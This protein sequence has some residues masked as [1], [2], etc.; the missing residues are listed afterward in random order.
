MI[1][2]LMSLKMDKAR[3]TSLTVIILFSLL[4]SK[5]A[6]A[7]NAAIY[8]KVPTAKELPYCLQSLSDDSLL[9]LGDIYLHER[10]DNESALKCFNVVA[11][12]NTAKTSEEA[13]EKAFQAYYGMWNT[14][15]LNSY[16]PHAAL[17]NLLTAEAIAGKNPKAAGKLHYA[18][19]IIYFVLTAQSTE[20]ELLQ[21]SK[22][23]L[24]KAFDL[25]YAQKDIPTLHRAF[26]NLMLTC[27]IQR[28]IGDADREVSILRNWKN[29]PEP[30]RLRLSLLLYDARKAESSGQ[31]EKAKDYY[32]TILKILPKTPENTRYLATAYS[33][34]SKLLTSQNRNKEAL[35][36]LDSAMVQAYRYQMHDVRLAILEDYQGIYE[37]MG[38]KTKASKIYDQKLM[39][40][41]SILSYRMIGAM[42]QIQGL[43]KRREL[44]QQLSVAKLQHTVTIYALI[45]MAL[46]VFAAIWVSSVIYRKNRKL[47]LRGRILYDRVQELSRQQEEEARQLTEEKHNPANLNMPEKEYERLCV[48]TKEILS[49]IPLVCSPDF[50]LSKLAEALG[51]QSRIASR[52]LN[53]ITGENFCTAVNR[54]RILEACRRLKTTK[55]GK[56]SSEGIALSVGFQS[57]S[58]FNSNFKKITG[59]TVKEYKALGKETS[60]QP[61]APA[62]DDYSDCDNCEM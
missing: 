24:A 47:T 42:S 49:D 14:Y 13:K 59:L 23:H 8:A 53:D 16:N 21:E 9:H 54:I 41:D 43:E 56:Y 3:L 1:T 50:T 30:W 29:H 36:A 48:R 37:S 58:A 7:G 15:M 34:I 51:V 55:Y 38:D 62:T 26:D 4:L 45:A 31:T 60:Q 32:A 57:R 12:R 5:E 10:R 25:S 19:G 52:I 20:K 46:I 22:N 18:Y 11:G 17:D 39:L 33:S 61:S 27:L 35:V 6:E 40:K 28:R 2:Y 44:E